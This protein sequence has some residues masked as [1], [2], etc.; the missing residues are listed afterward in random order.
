MTL[1][2]SNTK[3]VTAA[4]LEQEKFQCKGTMKMGE[5]DSVRNSDSDE[6]GFEIVFPGRTYVIVCE[7]AA[8]RDGLVNQL[9]INVVHSGWMKKMGQINP[10]WKDRY[11]VLLKTGKLNYYVDENVNEKKKGEIKLWQNVVDIKK[12]SFT[13]EGGDE[14]EILEIQMP[15]RTWKL[16]AGSTRLND[17]WKTFLTQGQIAAQQRTNNWPRVECIV[18]GSPGSGKST[19]SV[20]LAA[21][22]GCDLIMP[23]ALLR[24]HVKKNSPLGKKAKL[25]IDE[26][27]CVPD[28]LIIEMIDHH[29]KTDN[30]VREKG[31]VID[32]FP[33]T[34]KQ[35]EALQAIGL[36]PRVLALALDDSKVEQ[37]IVGR[38]TDPMTRQ[39][40][41]I[42]FAPPNDPVVLARLT[43]RSEDNDSTLLSYRMNAQ[44]LH[45]PSVDEFYEDQEK[46]FSINADQA[47]EDVHNEIKNVLL[48]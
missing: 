34:K 46:M 12:V 17:E 8:E 37:R 38:R 10:S 3:S 43:R 18:L 35:A 31:W 41:H 7:S 23:S 21:A 33:R 32:G 2:S 22:S 44:H 39:V 25:A 42:N 11:F 16:D 19:Q 36:E 26:G 45:F 27:K 6:N 30:A 5:A 24:D 15:G 48:S 40:Y 20:M 1:G 29:M 14:K 4:T 9:Q 47:I 28:E 13:T